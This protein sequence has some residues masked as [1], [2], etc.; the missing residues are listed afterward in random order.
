MRECAR[1]SRKMWVLITGELSGGVV[2]VYGPFDT[3]AAAEDYGETHNLGHYP[4]FVRELEAVG[5]G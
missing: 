3:Y 2:G 1:R 4:R 5:G